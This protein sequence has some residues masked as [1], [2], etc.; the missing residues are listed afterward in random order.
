MRFFDLPPIRWING[1]IYR[2]IEDRYI[3]DCSHA[4]SLET[5]RACRTKLQARELFERLE[6]PYAKGK[7]FFLPFTAL[8]FAKKVGYPVV[9]KPNFGSHSRGSYF[10]IR[11]PWELFVSTLK[12]KRW[13]PRTVVE[14]YLEGHNYRVLVSKQGIDLVMERYPGSV[15]GDGKRSIDALIDEENQTRKA[16]GLFPVMYPIPKNADNVRHLKKYGYTLQSVPQE[17]ERVELYHRVSLAP[18]GVLETIDHTKVPEENVQLFMKILKALDAELLGIDVIFEK[19][20]H[21]PWKD[22]KGIFLEINSR[23][24]LKMHEHPRWGEVPDMKSLYEK[25]DK[26]EQDDAGYF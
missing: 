9:V 5:R 16:M 10:P 15:V 22:Q 18:G 3:P 4:N 23:P 1:K 13:W 8:I 19:G 11:S 21:H 24:Y 20:I 14:Q 6:L 2:F 17:G 26:I 7:V 25:L 12:S